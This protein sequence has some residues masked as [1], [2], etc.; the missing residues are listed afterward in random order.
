MN[1]ENHRIC[2]RASDPLPSKTYIS[3]S[4]SGEKQNGRV[5]FLNMFMKMCIDMYKPCHH[6]LKR[7]HEIWH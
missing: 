6:I 1:S 5:P 2:L 7:L 3:S 4:V